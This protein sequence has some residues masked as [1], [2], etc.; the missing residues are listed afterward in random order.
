MRYD[1]KR[2]IR[3]RLCR[4]F[5]LGALAGTAVG[6]WLVVNSPVTDTLLRPCG[7]FPLQLLHTLLPL[8]VVSFAG[9]S[10]LGCV[11]I[12][13]AMLLRGF[14][15]S[16]SVCLLSGKMGI[17]QALV[18]TGAPGVFLLPAFFLGCEEA[19]EAA[20]R[21][22]GAAVYG[23]PVGDGRFVLAAA[24]SFAGAALRYYLERQIV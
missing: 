19:C 18:F 4:C 20:M 5:L 2:A 24:L 15:F 6:T 8:L 14:L 22:R 9:T 23:K 16:G 7:I 11:L 10:T 17:G 1:R 21:L 13:L 3:S 12:P